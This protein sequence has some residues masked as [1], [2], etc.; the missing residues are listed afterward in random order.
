MDS[1]ASPQESASPARVFSDFLRSLFFAACLYTVPADC[2]HT[3]PAGCFALAA[4]F[5]ASAFVVGVIRAGARQSRKL[6]NGAT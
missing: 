1:R 6:V 2:L 4:F 3:V 5:A